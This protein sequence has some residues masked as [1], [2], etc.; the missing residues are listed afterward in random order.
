MSE[1]EKATGFLRDALGEI[2]TTPDR[3][4]RLLGTL[5]PEE[6]H[7]ILS[8]AIDR[9]EAALKSGDPKAVEALGHTGGIVD[10]FIDVHVRGNH[11]E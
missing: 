2:L 11:P 4:A 10:A 3:A 8:G 5:P 6:R 7:A 9:Q 1:L